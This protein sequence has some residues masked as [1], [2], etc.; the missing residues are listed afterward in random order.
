MILGPQVTRRRLKEMAADGVSQPVLLIDGS[1]IDRSMKGVGYYSS[2]VYRAIWNRFNR[3]VRICVLVHPS[4]VDAA[5]GVGGAELL[6][7]PA[8]GEI[9][10]GLVQVPAM[11]R[12]IRAHLLIRPA[13]GC[14]LN[15]GVPTLTVCHD[16]NSLIWQAQG[17]RWLR[18]PVDHVRECLR[19]LGMRSSEKVVCNSHFVRGAATERFRLKGG[20]TSLGYCAVD[21]EL[22]SAADDEALAAQLRVSMGLPPEGGYMLVVATGDKREGVEIVPQLWAGMKIGGF[23]GQLVIAGTTPTQEAEFRSIFSELGH[24][25]SVVYVGFIPK[26][27]RQYL[28][29][30][31]GG[32]LIY[33]ETSKHEGFGMQMI[34]AM[35][36]GAQVF[37]TGAGALSEIDGGFAGVLTGEI[38]RDVSTILSWHRSP[39]VESKLSQAVQYARSY[40]W[41]QMESVITDWVQHHVDG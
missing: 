30:I 22:L 36:C 14:G 35:A 28:G 41:G 19:G 8:R 1:A 31:Y 37:T 27:K 23:E 33:L 25:D 7:C 4:G 32:A 11:L 20:Q 18:S 24:S 39:R 12:D 16:V 15:Y 40:D 13:E 26:E 34:E 3:S 21:R 38:C 29:A 17:R 5:R 9:Y 10:R 6:V 2:A